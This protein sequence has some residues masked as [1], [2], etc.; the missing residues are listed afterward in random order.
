MNALHSCKRKNILQ[1]LLILLLFTPT[2]YCLSQT[3][4]E[5]FNFIVNHLKFEALDHDSTTQYSKDKEGNTWLKITIP[6]DLLN[7]PLILQ[8][9]TIHVNNYNI[10][11]KQNGLWEKTTINTDLEGGKISPQY[12][13]NHF[14]TGHNTIYFKSK[15]SY[16]HYGNFILVER[17][18]YRSIMLNTMIK[19][20][21]FYS[22]FL[23]SIAL[24]FGLYS[25]FKEKVILIYCIYIV[26]VFIIYLVEDGLLYFLYNKQ[27]NELLILAISIPI[28]CLIFSLFIYY[29]L[30][31]QRLPSKLKY[32]Y[33][34]QVLLYIVLGIVL[35]QT[36]NSLYFIIIVCSTLVSTIITLALVLKYYKEDMSVRFITYSF[37]VIA[38]TSM[39]YYLSIFPGNYYLSFVDKDKIRIIYSIAFTLASY[40]LWIKA[41]KLKAD[42][43]SLKNELESLK[44]NQSQKAHKDLEHKEKTPNHYTEKSP[45]KEQSI[46]DVLKEKYLCTDREIDVIMGIWDGLSNQ[47]IAEKLSI[48][49]S[50][51]KHHVSNAYTKLDVKTRSQALLLKATLLSGK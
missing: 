47:E 34:F 3:N 17:A 5:Q 28:S 2:T 9:P 42:H 8:F 26:S 27:C 50:T 15:S 31:I 12:Q 37:S 11:A 30:D 22:L 14:I 13:E 36:N 48:S 33:S 7:K 19:I 44:A 6:Q 41:K 29:F 51:T 40:S 16:V 4:N 25:L 1:I 24:T 49:L 18:E 21:V 38:L 46:Q 39:T 43:E 35:Y 20:E 45:F 23:L 10:Y 32:F